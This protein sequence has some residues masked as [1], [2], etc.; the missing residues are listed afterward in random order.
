MPL[1]A[2]ISMP[3]TWSPAAPEAATNV[4]I[5]RF[6][7]NDAIDAAFAPGHLAH[8][9]DDPVQ[10]LLVPGWLDRRTQVG[11]GLGELAEQIRTIGR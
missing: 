4:R 3:T 9:L 5:S 1:P 2:S 11:R 7:S 10:Q 6:G 8:R